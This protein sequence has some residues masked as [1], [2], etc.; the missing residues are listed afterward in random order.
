MDIFIS[1][2]LCVTYKISIDDI[3]SPHGH[4]SRDERSLS[5]AICTNLQGMS[6][7]S[8]KAVTPTKSQE[9]IRVLPISTLQGIDVVFLVL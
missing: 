5:I 3:C 6:L 2:S 9:M 4:S 7:V 1:L 8:L